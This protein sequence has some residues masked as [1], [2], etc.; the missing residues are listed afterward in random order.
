VL[1]TVITL[2][3]IN[4]NK[5]ILYGNVINLRIQLHKLHSDICVQRET[6]SERM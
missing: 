5:N 6:A 4:P 3:N 1:L 2:A